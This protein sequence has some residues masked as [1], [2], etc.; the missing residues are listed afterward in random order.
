MAALFLIY[1]HNT[2]LHILWFF[3]GN[4]LGICPW[5]SCLFGEYRGIWMR[6]V[7]YPVHWGFLF[8]SCSYFY[9]WFCIKQHQILNL[10][11]HFSCRKPFLHI[12]NVST[13]CHKEWP[14]S[15]SGSKSPISFSKSWDF[16]NSRYPTTSKE[17][18]H[19][20]SWYSNFFSLHRVPFHPNTPLPHN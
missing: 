14:T 11:L 20:P 15:E 9:F 5:S 19:S 16:C 6:L 17:S 13:T 1:E 3:E 18:L 8:C 12:Q 4:K 10:Q 7:C 2:S